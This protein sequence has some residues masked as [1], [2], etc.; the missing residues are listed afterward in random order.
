MALDDRLRDDAQELAPELVR[1][2]RALHEHPEVGLN[3]PVTQATVLSALDGLG[4]EVT[5]GSRLSSVTAVLCS[6]RPGP[7][8]LL[9]GVLLHAH[10]AVRALRRDAAPA[11]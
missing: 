6:G 11:A 10:L 1:L 9:R 8:V 5:T 3:L 2:R 7:A 4:L